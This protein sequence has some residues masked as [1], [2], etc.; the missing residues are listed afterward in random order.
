MI[1]IG[2]VGTLE[3]AQEFVTEKGVTFT[4]LWSESRDAWEH[5]GMNAT[6]DFMLLDRFGNRLTEAA[7][8]DETLVE[9]LLEELF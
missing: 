3:I 6:S 4:A 7:P 2:G 9:Q 1:G 8:Y 5:Y